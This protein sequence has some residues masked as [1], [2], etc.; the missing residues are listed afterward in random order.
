[1]SDTSILILGIL[2]Y[3][4][5]K[6]KSTEQKAQEWLYGASTQPIYIEFDFPWVETKT[7]TNGNGNGKVPL[8][9]YSKI[10]APAVD[11]NKQVSDTLNL[12]RSSTKV[13]NGNGSKTYTP[14]TI[15]RSLSRLSSSTR[16]ARA[17]GTSPQTIDKIT[18]E[19]D[20]AKKGGFY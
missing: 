14:K 17:T 13:G 4:L 10:S 18:V 12:L 16:K 6:G 20:R 7:I 11:L 15:T 1:M 19:P 5:L 2:A 3:F 8:G 9:G